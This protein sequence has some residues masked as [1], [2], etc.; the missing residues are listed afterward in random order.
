MKGKP[1]NLSAS[2]L[3]RLRNVAREKNMAAVAAPCP[4]P[5]DQKHADENRTFEPGEPVARQRLMLACRYVRLPGPDLIQLYWTGDWEPH[6]SPATARQAGPGFAWGDAL[7]GLGAFRANESRD[8]L[9]FPTANRAFVEPFPDY[10]D[11]M[12]AVP[13]R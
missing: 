8:C 13:P 2:V 9:F 3:A 7:P 4:D 1:T 12:F 6:D 11:A 5:C 10:V